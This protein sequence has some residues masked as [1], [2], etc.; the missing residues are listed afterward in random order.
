MTR[1]TRALLLFILMVVAALATAAA[2][3]PRPV[4]AAACGVGPLVPVIDKV[5]PP[6]IS[7]ASQTTIT[8]R[9]SGFEDGAIVILQGY[10]ALETT[11]VSSDVLTAIVPAGVP[12]EYNGK[13]YDVSV[14]NPSGSSDKKN[15]ALLVLSPLPT[16]EPAATGTPVPT[17]YVRP[18]LTV[19]SYGASSAQLRSNEN[20]DF[21]M[22]LQNLGQAAATNVVVTFVAGDLI[23][24]STGGVLALG[25][26][27][28][29]GTN[30]FFQ[31]FTTGDLSG[32]VATLEAQVSYTD[33]Y[34]G[35]YS[36]T[37][38]LTFPVAPRPGG[39]VA[40]TPTPTPTPQPLIR[41]QL[42]IDS[43]SVDVQP[44]LPG[45]TFTLALQ[46]NNRGTADADGVTMIVGG[47]SVSDG[48]DG[49]PSPGGISGGS[50]EF[51]NFAPVGSSNVQLLGDL[52]AGASLQA[53][54][55]LVVNVSTNPGAYPFKISFT[56]VDGNGRRYVD[57]QVIT[58]LVYTPVQV[59]LSFYRD[60]N[61]IFAGQP[62][63][64]PIQVINLG[65][66][67]VVFGNMEVTTEGGQVQNNIILVGRLESG[68]YFTMDATLIPDQPGP[69]ALTVQ[70]SYS[71]D[72]N[73][74]QVLTRTLEVEVLEAPIIEPDTGNG[75]MPEPMPETQETFLQK[76]W[77]FIR[78]LLGLDSGV[79]TPTEYEYP[80]EEVPIDEGSSEGGV[81]VPVPVVPKG[82]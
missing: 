76:V 55:A 3:A 56:Y 54:Q 40:P 33:I 62:A 50:G 47:G 75:G 26:I 48:G 20:I 19:Y 4:Q 16:Q 73:Q 60:P 14:V 68:G 59:D 6:S 13:P 81:V 44:L 11:C 69:L 77:R 74:P 32:S 57:D 65:K 43:Y 78:G 27:T 66:S 17:A 82:P 53:A 39:G 22:T 28:A 8:V 23:P 7:N 25:T 45:A 51:T 35:T 64:L 52:A 5:Q 41:P 29:G 21:E 24:R 18:I 12:G 31:P 79:Q 37:F 15:N 34:G 10:G 36:E 80:Q 58:L 46:V 1:T 42:V 2:L 30:R 71:D 49:T 61:P 63:A 9:G 38:K 72:F 67:G 70:L